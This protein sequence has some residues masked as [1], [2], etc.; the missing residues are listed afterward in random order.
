RRWSTV[1]SP[2]VAFG[3]LWPSSALHRFAAISTATVRLYLIPYPHL[4]RA[5]LAHNTR[6]IS[7]LSRSLAERHRMMVVPIG[8]AGSLCADFHERDSG[9]SDLERTRSKLCLRLISPLP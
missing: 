4:S 9:I 2:L 7:C 3:R 6:T 1:R 5:Q 8:R